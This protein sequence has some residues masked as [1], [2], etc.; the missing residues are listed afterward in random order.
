M[1]NAAE[2]KPGCPRTLRLVHRYCSS[3]VRTGRVVT[4]AVETECHQRIARNLLGAARRDCRGPEMSRE[5]INDQCAEDDSQSSRGERVQDGPA[6]GGRPMEAHERPSPVAQ[7]KRNQT[8][9]KKEGNLVGNEVID[10]MA[11]YDHAFQCQ[12]GQREPAYSGRQVWDGD[13]FRRARTC[14]RD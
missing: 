10:I 13:Q 11:N 12:F 3:A 14:R 5:G 2:C 1:S 4:S 8:D 7:T 9:Y 6:P